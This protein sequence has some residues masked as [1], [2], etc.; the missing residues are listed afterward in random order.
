MIDLYRKKAFSTR[1][2]RWQPDSFFRRHRLIFFTFLTVRSRAFD[3]SLRRDTLTVLV[4]ETTI[5]APRLPAASEKATV[6]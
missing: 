1:A 2:Y 6:S 5:V 3:R 4:G